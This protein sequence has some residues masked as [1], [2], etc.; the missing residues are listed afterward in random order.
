MNLERIY[1]KKGYLVYLVLNKISELSGQYVCIDISFSVQK[2]NTGEGIKAMEVKNVEQLKGTRPFTIKTESEIIDDI[3]LNESKKHNDYFKINMG[4]LVKFN[5][6]KFTVIGIVVNNYAQWNIPTPFLFNTFDLIGDYKSLF[7]SRFS[8]EEINSKINDNFQAGKY[9]NQMTIPLVN[10]D[11]NNPEII[12]IDSTPS[13]DV[14]QIIID[15]FLYNKNVVLT[16]KE[17]VFIDS[18]MRS[19]SSQIDSLRDVSP[20]LYKRMQDM[21]LSVNNAI[22]AKING[23]KTA[24]VIP[25]EVAEAVVAEAVKEEAE[26]LSFLD[27][28]DGVLDL[29]F[30]D[31]IDNLV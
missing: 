26:D 2:I 31:D 29:S 5:L 14:V 13:D 30:L 8:D 25:V 17:N 20:E 11:E 6:N 1:V 4:D 15:K 9:D 3:I 18:I 23:T 21:L 12:V 27:D 24:R 19:N 7:N 10:V 22:N 16:A 28:I